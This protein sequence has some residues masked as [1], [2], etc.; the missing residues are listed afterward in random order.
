M[1]VGFF[2]IVWGDGDFLVILQGIRML[3]E[4]N[5]DKLS[6]FNANASKYKEVSKYKRV[7]NICM[8]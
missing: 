6:E 5:P 3:C 1:S 4:I 8:L 7:R 2:R